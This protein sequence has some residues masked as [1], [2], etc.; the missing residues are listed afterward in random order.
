LNAA[1]ALLAANRATTLQEGISFAA[2]AIDGK[3]AMAKLQSLIE[4]SNRH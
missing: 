2:E 3:A 1:A 4:F